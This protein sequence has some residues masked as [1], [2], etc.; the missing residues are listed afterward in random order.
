MEGHATKKRR[1]PAGAA[2]GHRSPLITTSPPPPSPADLLYT[3]HGGAYSPALT[4]AKLMLAIRSML[5]SATVREPPADDAA[6]SARIRAAGGRS[7]KETQW[8]FHDDKA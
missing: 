5:A 8:L 2:G 4:V 7:P 1:P 6:Y 3:G